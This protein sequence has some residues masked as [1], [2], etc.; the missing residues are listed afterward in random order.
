VLVLFP[1]DHFVQRPLAR[2]DARSET[3]ASCSIFHHPVLRV[4]SA[5]CQIAGA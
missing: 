3:N 5:R 4:A 1:S 2:A